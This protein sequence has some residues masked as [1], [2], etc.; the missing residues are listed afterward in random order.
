MALLNAAAAFIVAGK[1]KDLKEGVALGVKSLDG[2][3]ALERLNRLV[4]VSNA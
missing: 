1:A 2:G 3:A 4:A